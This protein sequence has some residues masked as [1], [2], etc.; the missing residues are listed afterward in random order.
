MDA[1]QAAK[2][3]IARAENIN[4]VLATAGLFLLGVATAKLAGKDEVGIKDFK[5]HIRHTQIVVAAFTLAHI[6]TA[7]S[8]ERAVGEVLAS[9]SDNDAATVFQALRT[10]GPLFFQGLI[11]RLRFVAG[12]G[13]I[14]IFI[15]DIRDPT[16]ILA[17]A[18]AIGAFCI[19]L[20][21]KSVAWRWRVAGF[22]GSTLLVATNWLIGGRWAIY[23]SCLSHAS[24][25]SGLR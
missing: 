19:M 4:I 12:P 15:M 1:D 7:I 11:S 5:F 25:C 23:A 3:I 24:L 13:G 10:G 6:F 18:M 2:I 16:T 21:W 20:R 9:F 8:F 14:P 22:V 17:H